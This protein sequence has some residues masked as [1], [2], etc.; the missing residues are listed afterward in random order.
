MV[1]IGVGLGLLK[2]L[3]VVNNN[4]SKK[5][6][7]RQMGDE[8][9]HLKEQVAANSSLQ[10]EKD[11]VE[12]NFGNS[13]T[14]FE[15]IFEESPFGNKIINS[16]LKIIRANKALANILGYTKEE[17]V[18]NNITAFVHPEFKPAW[19]KLRYE[20]WT[21]QRSSFDID[22]CIIKKDQTSIWCQVTSILFVDSSETLGYTIIEDISK[23][24]E[25]ERSLEEAN[26]LRL[27]LQRQIL[28][29]AVHA[30]E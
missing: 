29:N 9:S 13:Q 23:K 3:P 22:T 8:I 24:K 30:A 16:D 19:D 12:I 21:N 25:L 7:I 15:T 27:E 17:L 4:M 18:G 10:S 2:R 1:I 26:K 20:L 28:E 5:E 11:R 6:E 14:R